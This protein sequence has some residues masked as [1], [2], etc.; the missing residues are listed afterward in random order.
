VTAL[1]AFTVLPDLGA[2][3]DRRP[4]D[5][6]VLPV[7][8]LRVASG[9][10]IDRLKRLEATIHAPWGQVAPAWVFYDCALAPGGVFGF[11][12]P[13]GAVPPDVRSVL[14]PEAT[15]DALL[16][17]AMAVAIP[18]ARLAPRIDLVHTLGFAGATPNG[19]APH[20]LEAAAGGPSDLLARLWRE[21]SAAL[22][23]PAALVTAPWQDPL[24]GQLTRLGPVRVLHA[25][26]PAHEQPLTAT[27]GVA[28][29]SEPLAHDPRAGIDVACAD[30]LAALQAR[31]DAG[32]EV[33]LTAFSPRDSA[34]LGGIWQV[35]FG[36]HP[37]PDHPLRSLGRPS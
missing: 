27:L 37:M 26:N 28:A 8:P 2:P 18:T 31:L 5:S 10:F 24:I 25:L 20:W 6:T 16:P 4:P 32:E 19:T 29:A 1:R 17:V 22:D 21:A 13:A 30:D 11:A 35:R 7:D 23:F 34:P 3:S 15:D 14:D 36:G 9:P 12:L 33:W